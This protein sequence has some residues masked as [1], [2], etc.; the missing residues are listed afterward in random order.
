MII[1]S[2][3]QEQHKR[4][5]T[6]IVKV[7]P[8]MA[9]KWLEANTGNRTVREGHVKKLAGLMKAGDWVLNGKAIIFNKS[10]VL[11]DGQHRLWAC[12]ESGTPFETL[13]VWDADD[14]SAITFNNETAR[15]F[16]DYLHAE[17][18]KD[19][20]LVAAVANFL[21]DYDNNLIHLGHSRP[22]AEQIF[23]TIAKH[24][25]IQESVR[26]KNT[27]RGMR[28]TVTAG[29]WVVFGEI[30]DGDRDDF[31][32]QLSDGV[33]L[34]ATS[35]IYRLRELL[36]KDSQAMRR[37]PKHYPVA[38]AIKAWNMHRQNRPCSV[39]VYRTTEEFPRA[40]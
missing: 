22:V 32:S 13:V 2:L 7:T 33:G 21:W 29:L 11:I 19:S 5:R 37:A 31:F 10:G 39:L 27:V 30:A 14:N 1:S 26:V 34:K 18:Y 20:N 38:W 17:G 15:K 9:T 4:Q 3:K 23:E 25:A 16:S 6:E 40:A 12:L 35:P 8:E 28:N 24:P 36:L